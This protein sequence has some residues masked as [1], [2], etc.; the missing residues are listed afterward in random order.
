MK[1]FTDLRIKVAPAED[2][3]RGCLAFL[4]MTLPGGLRADCIALRRA[5]D[6]RLYVS[7]P[8]RRSASGERHPI[9]RPLSAEGRAEFEAAVIAEVRR[10]RG[11]N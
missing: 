4:E 2:R 10:Q 5:T 11:V 7:F 9:L 1:L 3:A 6:G 8:E